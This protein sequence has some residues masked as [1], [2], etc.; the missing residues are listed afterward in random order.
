MHVFLLKSAHNKA[1]N[2][3]EDKFRMKVYL[4]N[5]HKIAKHN[6]RFEKGEASF[7]MEMNHF[8]D[9]VI[10]LKLTLTVEH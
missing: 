9:L 5:R 3:F 6:A 4:E 1:Y 10:F 2:E 7:K 8:G